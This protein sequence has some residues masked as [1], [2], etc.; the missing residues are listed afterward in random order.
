MVRMKTYKSPT[1]RLILTFNFEG[2][3]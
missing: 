1:S 3:G 2:G